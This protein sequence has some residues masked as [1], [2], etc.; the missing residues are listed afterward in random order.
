[1]LQHDIDRM[2][3]T[4]LSY[5]LELK[6]LE[7]DLEY[8]YSLSEKGLNRDDILYLQSKGYLETGLEDAFGTTKTLVGATYGLEAMGKLNGGI[9]A[10]IIAAI[11]ALLGWLISK[12]FGGST[13]GGGSSTSSAA[14]GNTDPVTPVDMELSDKE[15][16]DKMKKAI[17]AGDLTEFQEATGIHIK[18]LANNGFALNA[19]YGLI[20]AL[21][22]F[23]SDVDDVNPDS[24][25]ASAEEVYKD[26]MGYKTADDITSKAILDLLRVELDDDPRTDIAVRVYKSLGLSKANTELNGNFLRK[27]VPKIT[28]PYIKISAFKTPPTDELSTILKRGKGYVEKMREKYDAIKVEL[29]DEKVK[30]ITEEFKNNGKPDEKHLREATITAVLKESVDIVKIV[31]GKCILPYYTSVLSHSLFI[32]AEMHTIYTAK[33]HANL[34]KKFAASDSVTEKDIADL[35]TWNTSLKEIPKA[36]DEWVCSQPEVALLTDA[37]SNVETL[38]LNYFKKQKAPK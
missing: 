20:E 14:V 8:A 32:Y 5:D 9:I 24:M 35:E 6:K 16:S 23:S 15:K 10:M 11:V 18:G 33:S 25:V 7:D 28:S 36:Y 27:G 3:A 26:I 2:E 21:V 1:M 38:L 17:S 37:Y 30:A 34:R 22:T 4:Q 12:I 29:S 13:N 31:L 19:T